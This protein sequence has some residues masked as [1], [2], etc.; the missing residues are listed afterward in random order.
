MYGRQQVSMHRGPMECSLFCISRQTQTH[1]PAFS[2]HVRSL[3]ICLLI[4][5]SWIKGCKWQLSFLI[6]FCFWLLIHQAP[7]VHFLTPVMYPPVDQGVEIHICLKCQKWSTELGFHCLCGKSRLSGLHK[8]A[9]LCQVVGW[10]A[11]PCFFTSSPHFNIYDTNT[12]L[13][14]FRVGR[15]CIAPF[16]TTL[17]WQMMKSTPQ[18]MS[19]HAKYHMVN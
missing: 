18:E 2:I 9:G 7:A 5:L 4:C 15:D 8:A 14:R 17:T 11:L 10:M 1:E 16:H 6:T 19:H 3:S 12:P 13:L